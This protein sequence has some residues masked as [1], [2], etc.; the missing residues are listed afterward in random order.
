MSESAGTQP[1][2]D[3]HRDHRARSTPTDALKTKTALSLWLFVRAG[4]LSCSHNAGEMLLETEVRFAC[5]AV[6]VRAQGAKKTIYFVLDLILPGR[7]RCTQIWRVMLLNLHL[8][9][10]ATA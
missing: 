10:P 3:S 9:L 4:G 2:I 6:R 1:R 7:V 5:E 8:L